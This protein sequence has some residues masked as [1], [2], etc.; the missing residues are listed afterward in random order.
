[1]DRHRKAATELAL[2]H[3]TAAFVE[4]GHKDIRTSMPNCGRREKGEVTQ[5]TGHGAAQTCKERWRS[6]ET[7]SK[8]SVAMY[9]K[10]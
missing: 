1:M 8:E 2:L 4:H 6:A 5:G 3:C 10:C 7:M 9:V